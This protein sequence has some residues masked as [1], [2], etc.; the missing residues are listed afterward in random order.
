MICQ[1]FAA[2]IQLMKTLDMNAQY[3][4]MKTQ[5][6]H[7]RIIASTKRRAHMCVCDTQIAI[8]I[9]VKTLQFI[10]TLILTCSK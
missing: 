2:I 10:H 4:D 9:N 8:I 5:S 3:L 7:R 6:K 1:L